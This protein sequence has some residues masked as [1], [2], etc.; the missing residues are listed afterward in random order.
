MP[1]AEAAID[2]FLQGIE[3]SPPL[4]RSIHLR[5]VAVRSDGAWRNLVTRA[6]LL[7]RVPA[8][9]PRLPALP[10]RGALGAWEAVL[11]ADALADLLDPLVE[12][13]LWM[14]GVRI[15]CWRDGDSRDADDEHHAEHEEDDH[16]HRVI[17]LVQPVIDP[18]PQP[19]AG[20]PYEGAHRF[21]ELSRDPFGSRSGWS[22]HVLDL[23]GGPVAGLLR[24]VSPRQLGLDRALS[25]MRRPRGE[26][27]GW[28][29]LMQDVL[30]P[31]SD[32][33]AAFELIA[34]LQARLDADA[35]LLA[36]GCV[37]VGL[38]VGAPEVLP[39]V[40]VE[41]TPSRADGSGEPVRVPAGA[42]AW[43]REGRGVALRDGLAVQGATEAEVVLRVGGIRVDA[44]PVRDGVASGR[45]P[46]VAAYAVFDPRLERLRA[47]LFPLFPSQAADFD[48]A[49][50]RLLGLAGLHVDASPEARR[51]GSAAGAALAFTSAQAALLVE[52]SAGAVGPD[53][54]ME[55][56]R[57]RAAGVAKALGRPALAVMVTA[58]DRSRLS[59]AE[60]N[61]AAAHGIALL[62]RE[63]L[64]RILGMCLDGEAESEIVSYVASYAAPAAGSQWAGPTYPDAPEDEQVPLEL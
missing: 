18:P 20:R 32:R 42:E 38:D 58:L 63:E 21:V 3:A 31:G 15:L 46:R 48:A 37:R 17:R 62:G 50:L 19:D 39:H 13:E 47:A 28:T 49:V 52:C 64:E 9:L 60:R 36:H 57:E 1:T 22:E 25:A 8:D 44:R 61:R 2:S 14:N 12:G 5:T 55:R 29:R 6:R 35:C 54:R 4:W 23:A 16:A 30:S 43:V 24:D 41:V 34:P 11:P 56:L 53:G 51:I 59:V 27:A 10:A 26:P 45:A 7:T 40:S 33:A